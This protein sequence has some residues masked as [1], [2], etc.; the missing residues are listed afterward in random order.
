MSSWDAIRQK[1][2]KDRLSESGVSVHHGK[3]NQPDSRSSGRTSDQAEFD[4]MLER[5]RQ[6]GSGNY[7]EV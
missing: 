2:E 7:K 6:I 3:G 5:E 4:A 1:Q